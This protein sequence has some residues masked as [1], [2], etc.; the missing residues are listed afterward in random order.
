MASPS[1]L[2][3]LTLVIHIASTTQGNTNNNNTHHS[4]I[5]RNVDGDWT[6]CS[7]SHKQASLCTCMANRTTL[8]VTSSG[9]PI[10]YNKEKLRS[11]THC[12]FFETVRLNQQ[13][14]PLSGMCKSGQMLSINSV[15]LLDVSVQSWRFDNNTISSYQKNMVCGKENFIEVK[16]YNCDLFFFKR[17]KNEKG[18]SE[19]RKM[20]TSMG[21]YR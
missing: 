3:I 11:M 13:Q 9:K 18:R 16:K 21:F 17:R 8:L 20:M 1:I 4:Q 10:C 12:K 19:K 14:I 5:T 7:T 6:Q 2:F 15:E